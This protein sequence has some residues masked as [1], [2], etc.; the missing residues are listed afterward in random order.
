MTVV[1]PHPRPVVRREAWRTT[2]PPEPRTREHTSTTPALGWQ[3]LRDEPSRALALLG[4]DLPGP[5]PA[6]AIEDDPETGS[7]EHHRVQHHQGVS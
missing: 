2:Q 4:R 3:H 5:L 6:G 7:V 1:A